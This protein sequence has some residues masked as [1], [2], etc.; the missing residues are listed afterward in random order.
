MALKRGEVAL[1]KLS[2]IVFEQ[3]FYKLTGK[4]NIFA[5]KLQFV[6]AIYLKS[7]LLVHVIYRGLKGKAALK[8][9]MR[10][11]VQKNCSK[12]S[13]IVEPEI[14]PRGICSMEINVND[15]RNLLEEAVSESKIVSKLRPPGHLN[16]VLNKQCGQKNLKLSEIEKKVL[17]RTKIK[18]QVSKIYSE[19]G[20]DHE[21]DVTCALI[22]LKKNGAIS[23]CRD[24]GCS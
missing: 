21:F 14:F 9:L 22:S 7:G 16:I 1:K 19:L 10:S 23:V 17:G 8:S 18:T 5:D 4:I 12:I 15:Y 3:F 24:Q 6:G 20:A 13:Y 11:M 2:S